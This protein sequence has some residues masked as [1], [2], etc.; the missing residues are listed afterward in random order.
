MKPKHTTPERIETI[1]QYLDIS[2]NRLLN[3][4]S[5]RVFKGTIG[6]NAS[7]NASLTTKLLNMFLF[8]KSGAKVVKID[9][10][11]PHLRSPEV[12]DSKTDMSDVRDRDFIQDLLCRVSICQGEGDKKEYSD[13][14][15]GWE[16]QTQG[17]TFVTTR[18]MSYVTRLFSCQSRKGEDIGKEFP[19]Y[20]LVFLEN[21]LDYFK[22]FGD[23]KEDAY[24]HVMRMTHHCYLSARSLR[25]P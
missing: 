3:M 16:M 8:L 24:Y 6:D 20:N 1:C 12:K 17:P 4:R 21:K 7:D 18:W 23:I 2:T 5:D 19:A 11:D 9:F 10:L 14:L 22:K 25:S 15:V 13:A